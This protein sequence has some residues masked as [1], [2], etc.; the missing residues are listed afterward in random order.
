M[1]VL[2][3]GRAALSLGKF[4]LRKPSV[5][6]LLPGERGACLLVSERAAKS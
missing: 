1:H 3:S 5:T 4:T 6:H 2:L